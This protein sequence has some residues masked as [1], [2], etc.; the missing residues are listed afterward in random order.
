MRQ[1]ASIRK[2]ARHDTV[3]S[4]HYRAAAVSNFLSNQIAFKTSAG[5]GELSVRKSRVGTA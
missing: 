1:C 4:L 3:S 2:Q 5:T